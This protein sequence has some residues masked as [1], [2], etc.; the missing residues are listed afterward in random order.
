MEKEAVVEKVTVVV[1]SSG[2]QTFEEIHKVT[3]E[4]QKINHVDYAVEEDI[5]VLDL[6]NEDTGA[7]KRLTIDGVRNNRDVRNIVKIKFQGIID[8]DSQMCD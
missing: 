7:L 4:Y 6:E 5:L 3:S 8:M 1:N 2:L